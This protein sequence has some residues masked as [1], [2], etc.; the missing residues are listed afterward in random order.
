MSMIYQ[1]K[2]FLGYYLKPPWEP[3]ARLL[4]DF[5]SLCPSNITLNFMVLSGVNMNFH[6]VFARWGE[7][8][9]CSS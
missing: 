2:E 1:F 8:I 4:V 9:Y 5:L 7:A 6:L 3:T